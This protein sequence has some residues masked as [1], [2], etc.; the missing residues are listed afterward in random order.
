M[1]C[2]AGSGFRFPEL[3]N[4][5]PIITRSSNFQIPKLLLFLLLFLNVCIKPQTKKSSAVVLVGF[6]ERAKLQACVQLAL[7][8][9]K[10][11]STIAVYLSVATFGRIPI[12]TWQINT[13]LANIS[14]LLH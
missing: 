2:T 8:T 9:Q 6:V 5:K 11:P 12:C 13:E 1:F 14:I 4:F 10:S 7:A 3:A